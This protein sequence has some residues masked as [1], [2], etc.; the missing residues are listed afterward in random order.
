VLDDFVAD[1]QR[2]RRLARPNQTQ[3]ISLVIRLSILATLLAT[4]T[5]FAHS[6]VD[7]RPTEKIAFKGSAQSSGW[8]DF[9]LYTNLGIFVPVKINGHEATAWLWGGPSSIDKD[10]AASIGLQTST[11]ADHSVSGVQI[12]VGDLT[13]QNAHIQAADLQAQA[14]ANYIGHPVPVR[15]GEQAFNRLTVDIDFPHHRIAF[16]DPLAVTKIA[17]AIEVPLVE[18]DGER[19]VPLSV[20]GAAPAQF[21]L[22]LGNVIGPLMVTPAFADAH[23]L[24]KGHTTS[25]RL[26]GPYSETVVSVEDLRFAGAD[27]RHAPIAII[28]DSQLPPASIVGGVGLPLLAKFRLVID[29]SHNRLYAIPDTATVKVPIEKDHIGLMVGKKGGDFGVVFVSPNSPAQAVGFQKG[30]KVALI[31]GKPA[32]AWPSAELI[33]FQMADIG[34]THVFTMADGTVRRVSAADFF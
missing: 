2:T 10:L 22:E 9:E 17:G 27:F 20:D 34:T 18:L 7:T 25:Q 29:Y 12:Q 32:A 4:S 33:K 11:E 3:E 31:D 15:L 8:V 30:D 21:E 5:V 23:K 24:L 28:P 6:D 14:Y 16:R 19:V 13:L 1:M 26:S